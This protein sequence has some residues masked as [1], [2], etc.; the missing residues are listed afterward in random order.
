[1]ILTSKAKQDFGMFLV[2]KNKIADWETFY[3]LPIV[4]QYALIIEFFDIVGIYIHIEPYFK[5]SK[6]ILFRNYIISNTDIDEQNDYLSRSYAT[7]K[8][9]IKANEIYNNLNQ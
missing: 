3:K 8:A 7:E 6:R 5:Y 1:M 2:N 9:I 4:C